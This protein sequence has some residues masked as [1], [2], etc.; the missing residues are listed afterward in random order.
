MRCECGNTLLPGRPCGGCGRAHTYASLCIEAGL[1]VT[2]VSRLLGHAS[3]AETLDTYSHLWP[4]SDDRVVE[5]LGRMLHR[6]ATWH[7]QAA[8]ETGNR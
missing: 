4:D 8:V 3:A 2:V 6:Q 7:E 1:P 5:A